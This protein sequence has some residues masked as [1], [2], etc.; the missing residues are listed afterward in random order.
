MQYYLL[1]IRASR[2]LDLQNIS[3]SRANIV[4]YVLGIGLFI[5]PSNLHFQPGPCIYRR[6]IHL[7]APFITL[8]TTSKET[9]SF[10]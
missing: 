7:H 3:Y 1:S 2:C 8:S 9:G 4:Y 5:L 10:G 6:L